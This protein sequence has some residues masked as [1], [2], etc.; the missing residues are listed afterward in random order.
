MLQTDTLKF[1]QNFEYSK[2]WKDWQVQ[3]WF[4][5]L[6]QSHFFIVWSE[7]RLKINQEVYPQKS[8]RIFFL[9]I[10][11]QSLDR[12]PFEFIFKFITVSTE[13]GLTQQ[14]RKPSSCLIRESVE[15]EREE[16]F[17]FCR[18]WPV[19]I[20]EVHSTAGYN[21]PPLFYVWWWFL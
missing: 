14:N 17:F 3:I 12:I 11:W 6:V 8:I 1:L 21:Q 16:T 19:C 7:E 15:I 2:V 20:Y 4:A 5:M 13:F 18:K 9:L 10:A